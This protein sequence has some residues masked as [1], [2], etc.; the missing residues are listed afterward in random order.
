MAFKLGSLVSFPPL[1]LSL[2]LPEFFPNFIEITTHQYLVDHPHFPPLLPQS[3][4]FPQSQPG[5]PSL[6][7]PLL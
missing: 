1:S 5:L 4:D 6:P 3:M 7:N 2:Y